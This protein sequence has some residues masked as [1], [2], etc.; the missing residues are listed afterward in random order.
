[1]YFWEQE[2][3][4]QQEGHIVEKNFIA[5]TYVLIN[6]NWSEY[7]VKKKGSWA[8]WFI[9][10]YCHLLGCGSIYCLSLLD[11]PGQQFQ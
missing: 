9:K 4:R 3:I 1:M 8:G 2:N 7:L 5:F 6:T 11:G 10:G